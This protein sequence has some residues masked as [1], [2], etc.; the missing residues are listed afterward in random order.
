MRNIDDRLLEIFLGTL[1][2]ITIGLAVYAFFYVSDR[3]EERTGK[4]KNI[5][6]EYEY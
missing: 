1:L 4:P 3:I 5:Q 2:F 6:T